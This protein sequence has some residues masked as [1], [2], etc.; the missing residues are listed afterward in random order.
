MVD[1]L[2]P[3]DCYYCRNERQHPVWHESWMQMDGKK[4]CT[5]CSHQTGM[6]IPGEVRIVPRRTAS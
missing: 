3:C 6:P 1:K 5:S 2:T 4:V